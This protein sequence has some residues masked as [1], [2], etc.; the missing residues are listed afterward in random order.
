ARTHQELAAIGLAKQHLVINGVLPEREVGHDALAAAIRRHEQEAL[1]AIP[2]VLRTLPID[3]L[4]LKA[5]NLV[6]VEALSSLFS[7]RD[8]AA[9]ASTGTFASSIDLPRLSTLVDEIAKTGHG[10]VM[11]M[12]KGGVGKTT[13][14]A[15]VA[16]ALAQ[17][18]LP[19]HLTTSDPAAH[20][21]DTLSGSLDNL[22]VS[23]ID[24]QA[25]ITRYRQHVLDTKGQDLDAD[26]RAMLE[27]DLRS[28]CTEEIAVFQAFSRI[29]REAGKKFVVMDT[30]PTGHTLLLLDATGAYHREATRHIDPHVHHT[31]PMMRLQDPERTK[32]M[33]VTLAETTPVLEAAG[34]QEE[35]RRAGIEPWAWLINNS[36]SAA[37][38]SSPL[39]KQR[40][41]CELAQI[42]AVRTRYAT[43]VALVPMQDKEPIGIERLLNLVDPQPAPDLAAATRTV[44]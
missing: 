41:A 12:G 19:V 14:A 8:E 32:V 3:H 37:T 10:L 9:P 18:G 1:A 31:T 7:D 44:L 33:I 27:E 17:R 24:P 6:G 42:E 13:L 38:T 23:R 35:L 22:E 34:L 39:L 36:L 2:A 21:T 4:P 28:P 5:V 30:A 25:E 29:I 20:L 16:V 40:A 43:R 11:M 15:A 26:G